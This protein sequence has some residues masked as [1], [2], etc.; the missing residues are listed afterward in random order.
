MLI[1]NQLAACINL[2][3]GVNSIFYWEGKINTIN[4]TLLIIKTMQTHY[5]ALE[6]MICAHHPYTIPE[7]ISLTIHQG[8][9]N[10]LTFI[11]NN[12]KK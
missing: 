4:E 5:S 2:I 8:L 6:S 7:I 1:E 11:E 10:Y 12:L 3:S 9:P